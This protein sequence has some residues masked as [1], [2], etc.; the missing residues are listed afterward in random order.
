MAGSPPGQE[1]VHRCI[2]MGVGGA[3][4]LFGLHILIKVYHLKESPGSDLMAG[5]YAE[6]VEEC[7]LLACFHSLLS[8]LS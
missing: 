8:L 7:G 5:T 6:A 4:G 3:K 1:A 2:Y